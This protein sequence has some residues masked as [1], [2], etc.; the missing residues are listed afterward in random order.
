MNSRLRQK[1][2]GAYY[3]PQPIVSTLLQW[4]VRDQ[5]DRFLDPACGDGRFIAAHKNTVGI[6]HDPQAGRIAMERAP[7]ALVHEGD[8]FSW[9]AETRERFTA[10]GGNPPFIRY[11]TFKGEVRER[12]L[13]LC[14]RLGASFSGL[15]SSWA[16]FVTASAGL[17]MPGGRLAFVVPAEVGHA[18]YAVPL[19]EYLMANFDVVH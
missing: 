9:A 2:F 16:P 7:W 1:E 13:S 19:L 6:E 5:A 3:T 10:V 17:L 11:Q 15:S 14:N 12:A 8:F 18:P 4:A